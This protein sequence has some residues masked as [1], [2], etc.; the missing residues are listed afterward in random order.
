MLF[1]SLLPA[2]FDNSVSKIGQN[3][4]GDTYSGNCFEPADEYKGD[5][6]RSYL[7]ISTVY[8]DFDHL[9]NSPMMDNNKYPVW[10][11]WAIDLLLKW[12]EQDPVSEKE[13]LRN[14]TIY[15]IQGNRNPFIDYPEIADYIWGEN[16][17][18]IFPF[19][20]ETEPFLIF[21][22]IGY[23]IDFGVIMQFHRLLNS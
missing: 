5:F 17:N 3:S 1:R 10:K 2:N 11:E 16:K 6:A 7:Y 8:Q 21:P 23:S 18:N 15:S 14:E 4:F 12:N 9:W 13:K 19:P 22:R 20:E